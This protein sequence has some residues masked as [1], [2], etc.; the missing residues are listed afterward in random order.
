MPLPLVLAALLAAPQVALG[1]VSARESAEPPVSLVEESQVRD[2]C[3][4]LGRRPLQPDS[5]DPAEAAAAQ[6]EREALAEKA[7]ARNYRIEI[8]SRGFKLGR[9][10]PAQRELELDGSFPARAIDDRLS[11]DLDGL[12][13]VAFSATPEQVATLLKEKKANELRLGVVFRVS[14]EPCAG[15]PVARAWRLAASPLSWQLLDAG[16]VVAAADDEGLPVLPK[17][18]A[19]QAVPVRKLSLKVEKLSLDEA[20]EDRARLEGVQASLDKCAAAAQRGGSL[21]VIFA[22][23]GGRVRDPQVIVDGVRDE[24]TSECVAGALAGAQLAGAG[25]RTGRGSATLAVE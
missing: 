20:E 7:A 17:A 14:G 12:D 13:D 4:A 21:V 9:Y 24:Q 25:G 22:V 16:G 1:A 23:Q 19:N 10:R 5:D 8:P 11:L 3:A 6:K 15:N 2:L 18:Q